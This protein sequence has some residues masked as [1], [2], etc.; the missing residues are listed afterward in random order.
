MLPMSISSSTTN[1]RAFP[2]SSLQLRMCYAQI[3]S[4]LRIAAHGFN[5]LLCDFS[6][7]RTEP[8]QAKSMFFSHSTNLFHAF[9]RQ[10]LAQRIIL[11]SSF[12]GQ[13]HCFS[14]TGI[15]FAWRKTKV[16]VE[17]NRSWDIHHSTVNH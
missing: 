12:Q 2:I 9:S 15:G 6:L 5:M 3:A 16:K 8:A 10:M 13:H 7:E 17:I 11:K 1:R 4:V 14:H